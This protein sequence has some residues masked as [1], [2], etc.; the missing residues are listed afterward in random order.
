MTPCLQEL[1]QIGRVAV[2][3]DPFQHGAR[4]IESQEALRSREAGLSLGG[5]ISLAAAGMARRVAA[6]ATGIATPDWLRPGFQW[7][8]LHE[9]VAHCYPPEMWATAKAWFQIHLAAAGTEP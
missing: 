3:F 9:G 8:T 7:V 1:A 5:D 4:R 2:S 6:V